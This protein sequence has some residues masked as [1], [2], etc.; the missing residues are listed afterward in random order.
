MLWIKLYFCTCYECLTLSGLFLENGTHEQDDDE[1]NAAFTLLLPGKKLNLSALLAQKKYRKRGNKDGA[2]RCFFMLEED[3]LGKVLQLTGTKGA[4]VVRY[5]F[6]CIPKYLL[7]CTYYFVTGQESHC[8]ETMLLEFRW[9]PSHFTSLF[10]TISSLFI[11]IWIWQ[12]WF[13]WRGGAST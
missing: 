12:G 13:A 3:G 9:N 4:G 2:I 11:A 5:L 1:L 7:Y 10:V 6:V 8:N